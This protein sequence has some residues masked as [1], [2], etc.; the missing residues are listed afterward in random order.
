MVTEGVPYE[1]IADEM[2]Y[3]SEKIVRN[4]KYKC[5]EALIEMI[6]ADPDYRLLS[7]SRDKKA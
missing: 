4:R 3:K 5:K 1:K 7:A 2:G 6:K